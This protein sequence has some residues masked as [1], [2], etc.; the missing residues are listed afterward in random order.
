MAASDQGFVV[1]DAFA[2]RIDANDGPDPLSRLHGDEF[3]DQRQVLVVGDHACGPAVADVE[4]ELFEGGAW[5]EGNDHRTAPKDCPPGLD[6]PRPVRQQQDDTVAGLDPER[7]EPARQPAGP[8][9]QL[10]IRRDGGVLADRRPAA[11]AA[12]AGK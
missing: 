3:F 1:R 5:I 9:E 7:P 10:P 12:G 2:R 6:E 8:V 4:A 11:K